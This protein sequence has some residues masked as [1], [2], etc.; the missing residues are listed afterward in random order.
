M[1]CSLFLFFSFFIILYFSFYIHKP[2]I[3]T[4]KKQTYSK[5]MHPSRYYSHYLWQRKDQSHKPINKNYNHSQYCTSVTKIQIIPIIISHFPHTALDVQNLAPAAA[6]IPL[7]TN[8]FPALTP[9]VL[10]S[11]SSFNQIVFYF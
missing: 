11:K 4:I 7:P 10:F 3:H 1:V 8:P 5:K 9:F 6:L 2:N